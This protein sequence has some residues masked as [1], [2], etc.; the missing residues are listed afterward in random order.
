[1]RIVR[2]VV[3]L[4]A[5]AITIAVVTSARVSAQG[6][7]PPAAL[8]PAPSDSVFA[9]A[10]RL[11]ASGNGAAG[12]LLVDS[13]VA[14]TDP[15]SAGYAEALYWRAALA[16]S[17]DDAARDYRR[18]VVEYPT[19]PRSGDA[20]LAL[21][22][23]EAASGDRALAATHLER[24]LLEN[25]KHPQR[26]KAGLLLAQ[27]SFD[28]NDLVHGCA[29]AKET[30]GEIP[31]DAVEMRNQL[32]YYLP[33]CTANDVN[34]ASQLPL[35]PQ[36]KGAAGATGKVPTDTTRAASSH[37]SASSKGKYTLQIAAYTSKSDAAALVKRLKARGFDARVVDGT[38]LYR[39]RVGHYPTR[40]AAGAEQADLKA[41]KITAFVTESG[42]DD[43]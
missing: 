20:L 19:S 7:T 27:I 6:E 17:T 36:T 25:P 21:A 14:A 29:A 34:P 15:D 9:R 18:I 43:P 8:P 38:K 10:Q 41:K 26:A 35:N 24:F 13:V 30:L 22:Q 11:V 33:R 5:A 12:R 1:M 3:R 37:A 2:S 28:Q 39:V 4:L 40:A 16:V 32:Q 42:A 23:L 31:P